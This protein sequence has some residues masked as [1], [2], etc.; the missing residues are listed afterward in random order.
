MFTEFQAKHADFN[1]INV[2]GLQQVEPHAISIIKALV[3]RTPPG[4]VLPSDLHKHFPQYAISPD[5]V[6]WIMQTDDLRC[7]RNLSSV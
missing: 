6:M 3:K 2:A 1:P 7:A 4:G 5:G